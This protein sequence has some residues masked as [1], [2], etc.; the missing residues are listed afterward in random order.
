[1]S[2][3]R[4]PKRVVSGILL[5]DK[6]L[7][8]S[9]NQALQRV[10]SLYQA[11]KAGH[12]GSLDPLATGMLPICLG[13]ATKLCGYLL[14]SDKR[15]TASVRFGERT[16]TGDAEGAVVQRS[17]ASG[18]TAKQIEAVLPRFVG[19]IQQVPPMYSA[20]KHEGQRLYALAREGVEIE[21]EPRTVTI[22][23]LRLLRFENGC[24]ELD[25]RCSKGTYVRTLAEDIAAA[26]G[27]CAHLAA[28][29]R[30]AVSPFSQ[31]MLTLDAL[32]AAARDGGE[33]ALDRLLLPTASGLAHWPSLSVGAD[34]AAALRHG[35]TVRWPQ[36]LPAGEWA[37]HDAAGR[38]LC[39]A[40]GDGRG[41][42]VSRRWLLDDPCEA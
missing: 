17:D 7:G 27:Q 18:L 6:P 41:G 3:P 32:E 39:I 1:M 34:Q 33:A 23:D 40:E 26:I 42:L 37:V 30:T 19:P 5:L 9:S 8:C 38:L 11:E 13:Q 20:L 28:L 2:K 4:R 22:H 10:R 24:A 35:R 14:D 31:A 21:R 16:A 25:V 15:Y 29:R 12:T 36:P